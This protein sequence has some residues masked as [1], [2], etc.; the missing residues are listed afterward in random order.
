[1]AHRLHSDSRRQG[2]VSDP[3]E[4]QFWQDAKRKK[5]RTKEKKKFEKGFSFPFKRRPSFLKM[6]NEK[7]FHATFPTNQKPSTKI[8]RP[9][10]VSGS[11]CVTI[12]TIKR[13]DFARRF[14]VAPFHPIAQTFLPSPPFFI[15]YPLTFFFTFL[16]VSLPHLSFLLLLLSP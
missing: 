13:K 12:G 2:K 15:L 9:I 7:P 4:T 1:M 10:I 11:S 16:Q 5:E 6:K 8:G 14:F 3:E